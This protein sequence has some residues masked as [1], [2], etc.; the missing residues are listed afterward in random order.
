VGRINRAADANNNLSCSGV[1]SPVPKGPDN[2]IAVA[3]CQF[4][5]NFKASKPCFALSKSCACCAFNV[6][7]NTCSLETPCRLALPW[8]WRSRR[9]N[10]SDHV[11]CDLPRTLLL[12]LCSLDPAVQMSALAHLSMRPNECPALAVPSVRHAHQYALANLVRL[13]PN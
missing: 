6:C 13:R 3:Y 12:V 9:P 4:E 5:G 8:R 10:F 7:K 2:S 1:V 11:N